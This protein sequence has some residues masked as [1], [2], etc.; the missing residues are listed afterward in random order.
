MC[1]PYIGAHGALIRSR[2]LALR[3]HFGN[4]IRPKSLKLCDACPLPRPALIC[5]L[6]SET[7]CGVCVL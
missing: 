4:P 2:N 1:L 3:P 5:I 7:Q 6:A